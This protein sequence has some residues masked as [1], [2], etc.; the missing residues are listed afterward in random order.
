MGKTLSEYTEDLREFIRDLQAHN[1]LLRFQEQ[2]TDSEL[3]RAVNKALA[4]FNGL[5][6][7]VA[8]YT[9]ATFPDDSLII[10][11]ATCQVMKMAGFQATRNA[12]NYSDSGTVIADTE[13]VPQYMQWV[14]ML[15]NDAL[16]RAKELKIA[17]NIEDLFSG[18]RGIGSDYAKLE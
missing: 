13:K 9:L 14:S 11:L 6:P 16:A 18:G 12:L 1:R 2:F 8:T 15:C 4:G 10:D 3:A 17:L 7:R 5:P